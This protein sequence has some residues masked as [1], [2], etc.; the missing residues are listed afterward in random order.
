M[1]FSAM[2]VGSALAHKAMPPDLPTAHKISSSA[3]KK[4]KNGPFPSLTCEGI[5]NGPSLKGPSFT[6]SEFMS[7]FVSFCTRAW[8]CWNFSCIAHDC[9][10]AVRSVCP[11]IRFSGHYTSLM[12]RMGTHPFDIVVACKLH[13]CNVR[14]VRCSFHLPTVRASES[15]LVRCHKSKVASVALLWVLVVCLHRLRAC[16][17]PR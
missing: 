14:Q 1:P 5:E 2:N 8:C 9:T 10:T 7:K 11:E 12:R 4:E 15:H 17:Q 16:M 3:K 6:T 13:S